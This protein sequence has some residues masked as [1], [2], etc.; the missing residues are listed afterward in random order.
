MEN[1]LVVDFKWIWILYILQPNYRPINYHCINGILKKKKK[2]GILC[3][4]F[5][6]KNYLY[7]S[8]DSYKVL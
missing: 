6:K 1:I 3:L 5:Y 2:I 4:C 7:L 8:M